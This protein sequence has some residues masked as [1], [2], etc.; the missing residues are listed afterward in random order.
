MNTHNFDKWTLRFTLWGIPV[1]IQPSSWLMLALLGGAFGVSDGNM[2]VQVLIFVAAGMLCLLAHEFGHALAARKFT[3]VTPNI[4][5]AMLG[6]VTHAPV[7]MRTRKEHF[8]WVLAGP[9]AGLVPGL[10]AALLLGLQVG[11]PF[12]GLFFLLYAPMGAVL[13]MPDFALNSL[14]QAVTH[15]TLSQTA[16][17]VYSTLVGISVWWTI[18]N[19]L[20]ILPMDGGQLLETATNNRKLTAQ[21]GMILAAVLALLC[22]IEGMIFG[23]LLLGYFAYINRQIYQSLK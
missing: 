22:L 3:G 6:G 1:E 11:N 7:S 20:P 4:T 10:A 17:Q 16:L 5:M 18:F 12:A 23:L 14:G 15:G 8:L 21:V 9:L 19:L 2:L 13:S